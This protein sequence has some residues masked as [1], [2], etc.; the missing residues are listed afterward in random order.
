MRILF[1][2]AWYPNRKD[3]GD[4]VFIQKHARAV[5]R[6]NDVAV[7]MVQTDVAVRGL[8]IEICPTE[9]GVQSLHEVLVYV[10]K[11]RFELP[12]ITGLLRLFWLMAGY[13]K[14]YRFIKRNYWKGQRP[15]VCHVNVLT[16]AAGLPWL[17]WHSSFWLLQYSSGL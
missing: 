9:S 5:A 3:A 10:P 4:G 1:T 13:I 12:L 6:L 14:G 17:L 2:T 15:E 11:T 8:S 7:L 16:R